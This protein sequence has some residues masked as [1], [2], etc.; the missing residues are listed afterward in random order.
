MNQRAFTLV[1]IL[2]VI[3]VIG[4]LSS[5]IFATT[6][7][8]REQAQ[9]AK[10]LQWS[11]NIQSLLGADAV[12]IWNLDEDPAVHDTVIADLSGWGN[13]GTLKTSDGATNKSV[14]GVVNNAL[15]F[16]GVN[17]YVDAGSGISN[18]GTGDATFEAWIYPTDLSIINQS[19]ADNADGTDGFRFHIVKSADDNVFYFVRGYAFASSVNSNAVLTEN[20]WNHI[21]A[22]VKG[23]TTDMVYLYHDGVSAGSGTLVD[24]DTLSSID[25]AYI[26]YRPH[27]G[28]GA[29]YFNGLIDEVRIYAT[30]L[31]SAQIKSQYYAGLDK[32]LAKSLMDEQEYF[33]R[34]AMK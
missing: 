11:R 22:V 32:L 10:T 5:I 20:Q 3:A 8:S 9:I 30:S 13:N 19:V 2:V 28:S 27:A 25:P 33:H 4:L 26:G 17:D 23:G 14:P 1:E 18:L 6:A 16:D 21:V 12:G 31:T 7:G 15:S 34:L 29:H 24:S